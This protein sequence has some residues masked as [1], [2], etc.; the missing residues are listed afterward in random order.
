MLAEADLRAAV[1][2]LPL[3][4]LPGPWARAVLTRLLLAPPAG[5]P[6][7]LLVGDGAAQRS[8]RFNPAGLFS[9]LYLAADVETAL[10]EVSLTLGTSDPYTVVSINGVLVGLLDVTD[11]AV[12]QRLGTNAQELTGNW[13]MFAMENR[14]APTQTLGRVMFETTAAIGL[15]YPS[16]RRAQGSCLAVFADRLVEGGAS[17]LEVRDSGGTMWQRLPAR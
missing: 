16:A 11:A 7:A 17:Y 12:M 13:R 2:E 5:V 9:M 8:Y 4:S 15:R 3:I 6:R 1:R 14:E 10:A